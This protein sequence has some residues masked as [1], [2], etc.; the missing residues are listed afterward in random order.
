M[1]VWRD[2]A[3]CPK[4]ST[5]SC[6]WTRGEQSWI[7]TQGLTHSA[8]KA[9]TVQFIRSSL[10]AALRW[11]KTAPP[12][13]PFLRAE[14]SAVATQAVQK[15]LKRCELREGRSLLV[16]SNTLRSSSKNYRNRVPGEMHVPRHGRS[17]GLL[18]VFLNRLSQLCHKK[19]C[20][21]EVWCS[22]MC[23]IRDLVKLRGRHLT[24]MGVYHF[25]WEGGFRT[26]GFFGLGSH[27]SYS[28]SGNLIIA[29]LGFS[30]FAPSS[31]DPLSPHRTWSQ[32]STL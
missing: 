2:W 26:W 22:S 17:S 4:S 5:A 27:G 7:P 16:P 12:P 31:V 29:F 18:A 28:C 1:K 6:G 14:I 3:T 10:Y 32:E 30:N 13:P 20:D 25:R 24:L 8:V 11:H 23:D 21:K 9:R 15:H 19:D